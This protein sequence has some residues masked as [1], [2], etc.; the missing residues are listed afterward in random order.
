V[1]D[2]KP[3]E[4]LKQ[5]TAYVKEHV[6]PAVHWEVKLISDGDP[7]ISERDS[8]EMQAMGKAME[9]VWGAKPIFR[10]EG[11]S[12]PVVAY[13]QDV[14]GAECVNTGFGLPDDRIHSP[15]ERQHIP[16]WELGIDSLIHFIYNLGQ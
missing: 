13:I 14:L 15:N 6:S 8:P 11:G 10:R 1:A 9:T 16:T 3:E 7:S 4:V 12:I 2:Q 5:M